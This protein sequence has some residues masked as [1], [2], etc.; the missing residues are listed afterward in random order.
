VM[1]FVDAD[2]KLDSQIEQARNVLKAYTPYEPKLEET[3]TLLSDVEPAFSVA[4]K[5]VE[6]VQHPDGYQTI[7]L[8]WPKVFFKGKRLFSL[9][10]IDLGQN[11]VT[12]RVDYLGPDIG[13]NR[14]LGGFYATPGFDFKMG[15][16]ALKLSPM[17]TYGSP[18]DRE[19]TSIDVQDPAFGLGVLGL[20]NT[21]NLRVM[22]G[23]ALQNNFNT[24]RVSYRLPWWNGTRVVSSY[25]S[26]AGTNLFTP[27]RPTWSVQV[28]DRRNVLRERLFSGL[29]YNSV[30]QFEDNF[31]PFSSNRQFTGVVKGVGLETAGR[32]LSQLQL[33]N[34]R[35]LLKFG[36]FAE[37]G[38]YGLLS[39]A[40]YSTGDHLTVALGGPT[41]SF[42]IKNWFM[43]QTDYAFG[44][45]NGRSPFTFDAY[46][47]GKQVVSTN[48]ALRLGPYVMIGARQVLNLAKTDSNQTLLASNVVY[49]TA[50][51]RHVKLTLG[52]DAIFKTA[53]FGLSLY[54]KMGDVEVPFERARLFR[55][56]EG[57]LFGS[58]LTPTGEVGMGAEEASS[59]LPSSSAS[60]TI[61]ALQP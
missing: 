52:Y 26:I 19:D 27:E 21:E 9:P 53:T 12:Q 29:W 61:P 38:A 36:N 23:R 57:N 54:P 31:F 58:P 32:W 24:A 11:Q 3:V 6:V 7:D 13:Y 60:S 20:Y 43:S 1:Q 33:R 42:F 4:L 45:V 59:P 47:F 17:L 41:F 8:Q 39:N 46:Y 40:L 48:N 16:G 30:G 22:A 37:L 18:I 14:D 44:S 50:G 25:N 35:P 51:P 28:Q 2:Y 15:P 56:L 55:P 10:G 5:N 49:I 34:T